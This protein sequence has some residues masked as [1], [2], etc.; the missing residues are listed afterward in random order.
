[1]SDKKE[2]RHVRL[3]KSGKNLKKINPLLDERHI[4]R[5]ENAYKQAFGENVSVAYGQ[6]YSGYS[7]KLKN[8]LVKV[9][10]E[11]SHRDLSTD[12]TQVM[13]KINT[14]DSL[15]KDLA[16]VVLRPIGL[17]IE[18]SM[19]TLI[20]LVQMMSNIPAVLK[21][22]DDSEML[23]AM[24]R[25]WLGVSI[26]LLAAVAPLARLYNAATRAYASV[27][28][29]KDKEPSFED[30]WQVV[31]H[32][33]SDAGDFDD[34]LEV[35]SEISYDEETGL[36]EQYRANQGDAPVAETTNKYRDEVRHGRDDDFSNED[37]DT[38]T[39]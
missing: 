38:Y 23:L 37:D 2:D 4:G 29:D 17:A 16:M 24:S 12:I 25:T 6:G 21:K 18:G 7:R 9:L 31:D 22:E 27:A 15:S 13:K 33:T 3:T 5:F 26:L 20:G 34:W 35:D 32:E 19:Q 1:M 30:E 11:T 14:G 36:L 10:E 39:F 8:Q 28:F